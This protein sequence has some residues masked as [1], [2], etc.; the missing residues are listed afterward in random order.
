[1]QREYNIG[2]KYENIYTG[3]VITILDIDERR[4]CETRWSWLHMIDEYLEIGSKVRYIWEK[5]S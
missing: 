2:D 1:M 5:V 4:R 3:C